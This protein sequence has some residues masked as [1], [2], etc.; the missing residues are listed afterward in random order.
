MNPEDE[1]EPHELEVLI[2]LFEMLDEIES[3]SDDV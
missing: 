2:E 1:L 3:E